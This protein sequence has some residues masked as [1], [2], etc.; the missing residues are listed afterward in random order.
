MLV[1]SLER[2]KRALEEELASKRPVLEKQPGLQREN[3][4]LAKRVRT[5]EGEL[6]RSA[7]TLK[8]S[9]RMVREKENS[10]REAKRE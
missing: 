1:E 3:E 2:A 4:E 6:D 9:E 10:R 8:S 5:L 7:A